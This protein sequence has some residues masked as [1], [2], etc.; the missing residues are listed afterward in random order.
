MFGILRPN[1]ARFNRLVFIRP[2]STGVDTKKLIMK[3]RQESQLPLGTC[4]SALMAMEWD[5]EK[6]KVFI[7]EEA[8]RQGMKKMESLGKIVLN[9]K[10][11]KMLVIF[12]FRL[13]L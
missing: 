11:D 12:L 7:Q 10:I 1:L 5:Y 4:R 8:K 2:A 9:S 3:L 13:I 6:A